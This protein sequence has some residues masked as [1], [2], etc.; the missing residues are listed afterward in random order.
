MLGVFSYLR[1]AD[2]TLSCILLEEPEIVSPLLY[3]H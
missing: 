1:F 2:A 3:K